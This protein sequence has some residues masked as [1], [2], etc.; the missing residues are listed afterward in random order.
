MAL[1]LFL[2]WWA[3]YIGHMRIQK[4]TTGQTSTT[5]QM[6][7]IGGNLILAKVG[8]THGVGKT[9][10]KMFSKHLQLIWQFKDHICSS[11]L[12]MVKTPWHSIFPEFKSPGKLTIGME[13]LSHL[14]MMKLNKD[15]NSLTTLLLIFEKGRDLIFKLHLLS[16]L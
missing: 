7:H 2:F 12:C 6:V 10:G 5:V 4:I 14:K 3:Y 16:D 11:G 1:S 13:Y 9:I 15:R 8:N